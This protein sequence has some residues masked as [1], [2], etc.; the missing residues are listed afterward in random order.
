MAYPFAPVTAG[1]AGGAEQVLA[2]LDMALVRT[3]QRSVVI[4]CEGSKINGTLYT[5]PS[6]PRQIDDTRR[7]HVWASY[8]ELIQKVVEREH[9]DVI[10]AH[11]LDFDQYLPRPG[12]PLLATLHLPS[13]WY[14][15]EALHPKRPDTVLNCVSDSQRRTCPADSPIIGT[16]E[17]GV[18]LDEYRPSSGSAGSYFAALGRICPEKGY[19]LALEAALRA[20]VPL[21]IAGVTFPY[22]EHEAYLAR[23][24]K[25]RLDGKRRLLPALRGAAKRRLLARARALVI[26]SLVD[27]T[28]SLVAREALACGTPVIAFARGALPELIESGKNG[29]LVDDVNGLVAAFGRV[30]EIDRGYCRA[31]A[32][33]RADLRRTTGRYLDLYQELAFGG[34]SRTLRAG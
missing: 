27:E 10:H 1:T 14:S 7:E 2:A 33:R 24:I 6:V 13:S 8:R 5:L 32:E 21:L 28:S 23:E 19:A 12:T 11:G 4:A 25:P 3:G 31:S 30:D 20:R 18:D 15:D 29:F 16:I 22:P 26:P 34:A 17:N 9:V